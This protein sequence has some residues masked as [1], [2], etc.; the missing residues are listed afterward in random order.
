MMMNRCKQRCNL[1]S[2]DVTETA[3]PSDAVPVSKDWSQQM[4]EAEKLMTLDEY[5]KQKEEKKKLNQEKLP[6]FNRRTAGEGEDP[7]IWKQPEQVY[8]KKND[9]DDD[10]ESAGEGE[11]GAEESGSGEEET[12]EE[13]TSGRK[14]IISIPLQFKPIE[15]PRGPAGSYGS[16]GGSRRGGGGGRYNDRPNRDDQQT[17]K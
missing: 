7:K 3:T 1:Y 17:C 14:R 4:D 12:E 9:D 10:D 16:K 6:Q 13:Q 2:R 11:S 5:R 15:G 8:R